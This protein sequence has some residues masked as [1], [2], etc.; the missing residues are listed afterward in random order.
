MDE[1]LARFSR[2]TFEV[3]GGYMMVVDLQGALTEDGFVLTDPVVL[4]LD[5]RRFGKS[6]LGKVA[7]LRC[8]AALGA[9]L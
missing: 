8:N 6:N 3:T 5:V 9:Y 7:M 1:S 4:C 2:Y